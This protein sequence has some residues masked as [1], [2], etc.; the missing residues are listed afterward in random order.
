[1]SINTLDI[2]IQKAN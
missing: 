1:V 2:L